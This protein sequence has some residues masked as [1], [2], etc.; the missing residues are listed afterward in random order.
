M[1][2]R[3]NIYKEIVIALLPLK[4][5]TKLQYI[6]YDLGQFDE[7]K[8]S[9]PVA[10]PAVLINIQSVQFEH[11]TSGDVE[12]KDAIVTL[13]VVMDNR[14]YNFEGAE[15]DQDALDV[16]NLI[17]DVVNAAAFTCGDMFTDMHLQ[18]EERLPYQFDGLQ[19]HLITFSTE[20]YFQL[21]Q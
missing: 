8:S 13:L 6:G 18:S 14:H 3:E 21:N 15:G 12:G 20:V 7:P 1:N 16:L 2:Y 4:T 9:Y 5:P 19:R 11:M 17:D 10:R